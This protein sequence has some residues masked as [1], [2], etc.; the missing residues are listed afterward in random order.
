[1][2]RMGLLQPHSDTNGTQ[3]TEHATKPIRYAAQPS[4][5]ANE[6]APATPSATEHTTK[7]PS[8]PSADVRQGEVTNQLGTGPGQ[9][10]LG[11]TLPNIRAPASGW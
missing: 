2:Y 6:P 11:R 9:E 5:H 8:A 4:G 10:R 3:P 1:M 7:A